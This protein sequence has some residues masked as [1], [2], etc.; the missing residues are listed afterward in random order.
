MDYI[1]L[2][3]RIFCFRSVVQLVNYSDFHHGFWICIQEKSVCQW[4]TLYHLL[5]TSSGKFKGTNFIGC[6]ILEEWRSASVTGT[7]KRGNSKTT[8]VRLSYQKSCRG[9]STCLT[10]MQ[11]VAADPLPTCSSAIQD[12]WTK[13]AEPTRHFQFQYQGTLPR[14]IASPLADA[15]RML[16]SWM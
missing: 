1:V 2:L 15:A 11:Y 7:I 4:R 14:V 8:S 6:N 13:S 5:W 10:N 9:N 3:I 12:R 16:L